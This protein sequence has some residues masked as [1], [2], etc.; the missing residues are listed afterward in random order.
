[1]AEA[2][3]TLIAPEQI[4]QISRASPVPRSLP[5][6]SHLLPLFRQ[7][8]ETIA[9]V[10]ALAGDIDQ[11]VGGFQIYADDRKLALA[12]QRAGELSETVR[13]LRRNLRALEEG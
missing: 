4:E 8:R 3:H 10:T 7:A 9:S 5:A 2:K 11:A 6:L 12:L 13:L 1:M